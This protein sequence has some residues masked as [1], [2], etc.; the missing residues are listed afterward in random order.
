VMSPAFSF[1]FF[2][3]ALVALHAADHQS[4][5]FCSD[6]PGLGEEIGCS[7]I[8][9]ARTLPF[10]SQIK[11][12]VPLVPMSIPSRWAMRGIVEKPGGYARAQVHTPHYVLHISNPCPAN[13]YAIR[14]TQYLVMLLN[15]HGIG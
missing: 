7:A 11:V 6:Q 14:N 3:T 10:W 12:F 9:V 2:K 15:C 4:T 8:A 5:G 1:D 13:P